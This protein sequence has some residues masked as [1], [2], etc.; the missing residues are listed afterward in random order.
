MYFSDVEWG[1]I[2]EEIHTCV[3]LY[4]TDGGD[5]TDK[6]YDCHDFQQV[7]TEVLAQGGEDR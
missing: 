6:N 4:S 3:R 7:F 1:W 2:L 5:R